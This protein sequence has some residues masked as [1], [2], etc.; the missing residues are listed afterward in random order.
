[1][2]AIHEASADLAVVTESWLRPKGDEVR[3]TELT[4]PGYLLHSAPRTTGGGGGIAI[5]YRKS[6]QKCVTFSTAR[7]D[8]RTFELCRL[9]VKLPGQTITIIALY[10]PTPSKKNKLTVAMFMPEFTDLLDELANSCPKLVILG[11]INL[12]FDSSTDRNVRKLKTQLSTLGLVQPVNEPTHRLGHTLDWVIAS[13]SLSI[14][15]L[16][17]E[18]K[19]ISDHF[20]ISF[21][22]NL[23]KPGPV[24]RD[25]TSRDLRRVDLASFRADLR[26]LQFDED[27]LAGSYNS[28]V[29]EVLDR[30]APLATR[31]VTDR[32]SAPWLTLEVKRARQLRRQAERRWH[33]TKLTVHRQ[34]YD[35]HR[36]QVN[37]LVRKLKTDFTTSKIENS[38]SCKELYRVSNAL[39]GKQKDKTY[40]TNIKVDD[41][42]DTF[43]D[44]FINK[45]ASI[46][47]ELDTVSDCPD[48]V[49]YSGSSLTCFRP[50][51]MKEVRDIVCKSSKKSC[52]LDP[53]PTQ[54]LHECLDELLPVLTK[55]V[56]QSLS[57]GIFPTAFKHA[58]ISPL[59]KKAQLDKNL[60]KNYRPVSNLP[61]LSKILEKVVLRQ[62]SDHL[63]NTGMLEIFQSAYRPSHSTETALIRITNELL[64]SCDTGRVS[65][66]SLLDLSAAFDTL[67]HSI[68][69]RRL[70][71]SFGIADTTL[72]WF[73]SYLEGRTQS[74]V[75]GDRISK[76][77]ALS[78][79]VPQGSVLG[80]VLFTLYMQPLGDII[81]QRDMLY[82]MFA[83]DTQLLN[84][85]HPQLFDNL[86]SKV[87]ACVE[88]VKIWMTKNKL[89]MNNEKTE[90]IPI[91][92]DYMLKSISHKKSLSLSESVITFSSSVRNLGV[93]LDQSLSME[94]H[95]TSLC[96]S[97][98]LE[99]RRLSQLRPYLTVH[100]AKTLMSAFVLSRIDYCNSLLVGLPDTKLNRLQR[101]QNNAARVVLGG[102]KRDHVT[103]LLKSLHWLPVKARIEYKIATLC[104]RCFHSTAPS[105]L[106]DLLTVH[107]PTRTLRSAD[108]GHFC[109]PR[110]KLSTYGKRSFSH[111]GPKTWNSLPRHVRDSP[112]LPSFRT[113][114]KT[115]LFSK[116]FSDNQ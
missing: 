18:N 103:P 72:R 21:S 54:L 28:R 106:S 48:F 93:H 38:T 37:D 58:T 36:R 84:S 49:P 63:A 34:I 15:E 70:N 74:V 79:G 107:I 56:N 46:R 81:H 41:L 108:A 82:H 68:L 64:T 32:P 60:L 51:T 31:R 53:I 47:Q 116:Y 25:V 91:G 52:G 87:S 35:Y 5:I 2:D 76:R 19:L 8:F 99:L 7:Y 65:V 104:Y 6:L 4:P 96:R 61:F 16:A 40:P 20:T 55:I 11:D 80:P 17:V 12:H 27:D 86:T 114:L 111:I 59:L 14:H 92:T 102:R 33:K 73:K 112:S 26:S 1:M 24:K 115:Y 57:T 89:K 22:L 66:L 23:Q 29:G 10:R 94:T 88:S 30:H 75:V 100:A 62:L 67:D 90:I 13:D 97:L 50:V 77:A 95:I 44:Y 39:L 45:I 113:S 85:I 105:Y 110:V 78:Y 43:C 69:L 9:H 42:P 3:E 71:T 83:D 109:V 101:I 98:F